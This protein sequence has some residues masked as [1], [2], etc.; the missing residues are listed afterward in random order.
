MA[1][2]ILRQIWLREKGSNALDG[3]RI[4]WISKQVKCESN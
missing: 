1:R 4:R 3:S 2:F